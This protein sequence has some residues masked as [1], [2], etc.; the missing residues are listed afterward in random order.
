MSA[1]DS[2]P[3]CRFSLSGRTACSGADC[4]GK[5]LPSKYLLFIAVHYESERHTTLVLD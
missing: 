5:M 1:Q 2:T 3:N 4:D